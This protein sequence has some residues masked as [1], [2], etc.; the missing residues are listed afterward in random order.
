VSGRQYYRTLAYEPGMM[1]CEAVANF[2]VAD[3]SATRESGVK[4]W[5]FMTGLANVYARG[6]SC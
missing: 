4:I 2:R 3:Y 6:S 1:I 5:A